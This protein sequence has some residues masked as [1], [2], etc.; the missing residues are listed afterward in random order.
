M[1]ILGVDIGTTGCKAILFDESFQEAAGAYQAYQLYMP[2]N[3]KKELNPNEVKNAVFHCIRQCCRDG[4][5]QEV[6]AIA[7]SAQGE[8]AIAVGKNGELLGNTMVSFDTRNKEDLTRLKALFSPEKLMSITGLP[9][10]TMF[11]L[12]KLMWIKRVQPYIY[13]KTWK[14]MCFADY[15]AYVLGAEPVMDYSLAS[16]TMLFDIESKCWNQEIADACGLDIEKLPKTA[17]SGTIIGT[18][19][20]QLAQELGINQNAV[21]VTG[22]HDQVCCGL[23][24]GVIY[25]GIAMNSMG[26][27]DSIMCV[28]KAFTSGIQQRDFNIPCGYYYKDGIFA[29]HSFVLT[30]GNVIEWFRTK[31]FQKQP[32]EFSWLEKELGMYP[33]PTG[34]FFVPHFSGAGTPSLN[35]S[36]K[37]CCL[38][39]GLDTE[40]VELYKAILEG[41]AFECRLN[42]ENMEYAGIRMDRIRCLGGAAA[43][44]AYL[45]IKADIFGKKIEQVEV[46]EAG[47]FGAALMAAYGGKL[48]QSYDEVLR[49]RSFVVREYFPDTERGKRYGELFQKY[50]ELHDWADT[51][52]LKKDSSIP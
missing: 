31:L 16:R 27:T 49:E 30:T 8:A 41:I 39:L 21:I 13:D 12:P 36:S 23:G 32:P 24:A 47:C 18:V 17:P 4:R 34:M 3:E 25:D 48:I 6:A 40:P 1:N 7:F 50:R 42:I 29:N 14:F 2:D 11:T 22:G 52:Y 44:S 9:L 26:T 5:G 51:F 45:Q 20:K 28:S 37:G 15:M 33:S 38:G 35:S 46:K 10:H 19:Q 43:S